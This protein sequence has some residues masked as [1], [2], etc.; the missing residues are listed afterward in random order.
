MD[1]HRH[2]E[3]SSF[4]GFGKPRELAELAKELGHTALGLSN[5]GNTNNLVQHYFACKEFGIKPILGVEGY[6]LP[7]YKEQHRGYHLCL[8]AK[9]HQGYHNLNVL[10]YEGEK[11]KYYNPI[12]TFDMLEKYHDGLI[13]S[14][15]CIAGYLAQCL[16][17]DKMEMARK[18]VSKMVDIFGDDFYI[19]IQPYKISEEG[20]QERVNVAAIKLAKKMG[21]KCIMTSDSHRGAKEDFPTYLKMHEIAGHDLEHIRGTYKERYMPSDE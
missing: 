2:D 15:A 10:Q 5:H 3:C 9:N 17:D 21:V 14:S 16:K 8:F 7:K 20:L 6:F 18:F 19:E 4:D 11:I 13:C 12:W 1:L